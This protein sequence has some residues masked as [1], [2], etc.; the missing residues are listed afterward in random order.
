MTTSWILNSKPRFLYVVSSIFGMSRTDS[1]RLVWMIALMTVLV[2]YDNPNCG[3]AFLF[4]PRERVGQFTRQSQILSG[5]P[6]SRVCPH[7]QQLASLWS[8]WRDGS[9]GQ[10]AV[11]RMYR[12]EWCL[13][14]GGH[15]RPPFSPHMKGGSFIETSC[16][17]WGS[18]PLV[19]SRT[20]CGYSPRRH[21]W[22][23]RQQFGNFKFRY[24][25][26]FLF[27]IFLDFLTKGHHVS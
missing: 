14:W 22:Q 12:L 6:W 5:R 23:G 25:T 15:T 19:E 13:W 7:D 26:C 24:Y 3:R 21:E 9:W 17:W 4:K 27:S 2:D 8:C 10:R 11:A 18:E 1:R 16:R 20:R